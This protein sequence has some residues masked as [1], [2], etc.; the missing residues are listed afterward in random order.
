MA[1]GGEWRLLQ[2]SS[3]VTHNTGFQEDSNVSW[4]LSPSTQGVIPVQLWIYDSKTTLHKYSNHWKIDCLAA[5]VVYKNDYIYDSFEVWDLSSKL[6]IQNLYSKFVTTKFRLQRRALVPYWIY[7]QH[8]DEWK[9]RR[10]NLSIMEPPTVSTDRC[11]VRLAYKSYFFSQR[12]IFFSH[13]KSANSTFSH[14]LSAKRTGQTALPQQ[15]V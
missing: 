14:G 15:V 1:T 5:A 8:C 12:T 9:G 2:S 13:N 11:P 3:A 4:A 7:H 10:N 6:L